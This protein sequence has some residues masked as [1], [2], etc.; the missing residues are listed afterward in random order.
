M[1]NPETIAKVSETQ[2]RIVFD[3]DAVLFSD[4]SQ[5]VFNERKLMG[6][7]EHEKKNADVP[8]NQVWIVGYC[9]ENIVNLSKD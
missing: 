1:G 7:L 9:K 5:R 3:G 2:L 8:M 6:Y 4:E